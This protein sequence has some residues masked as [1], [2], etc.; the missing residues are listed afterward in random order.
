[1]LIVHT[2]I[3]IKEGAMWEISILSVQFFCDLSFYK[4]I[5]LKKVNIGV[6]KILNTFIYMLFEDTYF[7]LLE[8]IMSFV[9]FLKS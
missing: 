3:N 9:I 2:A 6:Y 8:M 1:M 5:W 4:K 7:P